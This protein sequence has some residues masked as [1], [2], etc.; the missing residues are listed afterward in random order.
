MELIVAAKRQHGKRRRDRKRA[1]DNRHG[2]DVER[3]MKTSSLIFCW[4]RTHVEW[5]PRLSGRGHSSM[6]RREFGEGMLR[7]PNEKGSSNVRVVVAT[8]CVN[9]MATRW[10]LSPTRG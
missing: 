9:W 7:L 8:I 4:A 6:T 5:E 2:G 3:L 1:S 10:A